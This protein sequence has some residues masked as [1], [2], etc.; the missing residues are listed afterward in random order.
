QGAG[1]YISGDHFAAVDANGN[2]WLEVFLLPLRQGLEFVLYRKTAVNSAVEMERALINSHNAI[3]H[4]FID[5]ALLVDN[6]LDHDIKIFIEKVD[7]QVRRLVL[8]DFGESNY[9][10][11][12][13]RGL[14]GFIVKNGGFYFPVAHK[15]Q[16]RFIDIHS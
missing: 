8:T 11:E 4:E 14:Y 12:S 16:D 5:D 2:L 13:Y 6:F 9:I 15:I 10:H 3:A 1:T 7:H